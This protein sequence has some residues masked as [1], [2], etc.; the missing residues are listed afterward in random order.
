MHC[1]VLT[2]Y[3]EM[4]PGV[5]AHGVM[6][7]ALQRNIWS[8]NTINIRDFATG[9]H[10]TVDDTP[11][12]GGA[13]MVMKPDVVGAAID[14]ALHSA[15]NAQLI[16]MT[17]IGTPLSQSVIE[18]LMHSD[19]HQYVFLCG[20]FEGIDQRVLDKYAPLE[21]SIGDYVLA[22]GEVAAMVMMEAM[23]RYVSGVLGNDATHQD[24]SFSIGE[25]SAGLLEYPHYTKPPLWDGRLV[26]DVLTSGHHGHISAWRRRQA[27]DVTQQR[28]PD[29]WA[30]YT[31]RAGNRC[32]KDNG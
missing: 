2:L 28:R 8:L 18:R 25:E 17:P 20:R 21:V 19:T 16:Y 1:D 27:E 6:G 24:E 31:Q 5:L 11:Y 15:P 9:K 4:F 30:N 14:A 3:P 12:G 22:G 23:L 29:L 13:G 26:P 32:T 7:R 10:Q